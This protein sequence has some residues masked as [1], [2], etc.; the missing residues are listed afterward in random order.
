[1]NQLD[2]INEKLRY[3]VLQILNPSLVW[4]LFGLTFLSPRAHLLQFM[5]KNRE[6][7]GNFQNNDF[8]SHWRHSASM[9]WQHN[10]LFIGSFKNSKS[11]PGE[12]ALSEP[13]VKKTRG[14]RGLQQVLLQKNCLG[15]ILGILQ[16]VSTNF[17]SITRKNLRF[18]HTKKK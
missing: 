18:F 13:E 4:T 9:S 10:G 14:R 16:R 17:A 6:E 15:D 7:H 2:C 3:H 5:R 8:P 12:G 1:M 11:R